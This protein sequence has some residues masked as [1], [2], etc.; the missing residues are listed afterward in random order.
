MADGEE[1]TLG[2]PSGSGLGGN[3]DPEVREPEE[4]A[5]EEPVAEQPAEQGQAEVSP[6]VDVEKLRELVL[7]A[8][9]EA[10]PE[11][12]RGE[13]LE[14]LEASARLATEVYRRIAESVREA[15]R[16]E[17]AASVPAGQPGRQTYLV[18]VEA[19]SPAAK[20]AEGLRRR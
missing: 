15:V 9:P 19:L 20:I 11:L 7:R 16:R 1:K 12:V 13:T 5:M 17:A 3:P 10:I 6:G 2:T 8:H 4:R 14:E 18:N